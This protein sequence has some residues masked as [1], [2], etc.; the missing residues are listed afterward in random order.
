M[1]S[2][3]N[4][5][6]RLLGDAQ[7]LDAVAQLFGKLDIHCLQM[8]DAF[9]IGLG[10]R[11][12]DPKSN[13]RQDTAFV[14]GINT[15]NVE[16]RVGFGIAK[17]LGLLE[18]SLKTQA[19]FTHFGQD[20]IG[21]A[22]DDARQP[23][24]A[25][26]AQALA[27]RFDDG[28]ATSHSRFKTDH[29]TLALGSGKNLVAM[30]SQQGLVGGYHV[31]ASVNGAQHQL[32]GDAIA[33]NQFDDDVNLGV[34]DDLL[35]VRDHLAIAANQRMGFGSVQVG[36]HADDHGAAQAALDFSLVA[37]QDFIS[38]AANRSQSQQA[39]LNGFHASAFFR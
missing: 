13:R 30:H 11:H 9:N 31:F 3:F 37:L 14:G 28:N 7:Q 22:V 35:G 24:D 32:E 18:C 15:L 26:G 1:Y 38:A 16:C 34:G 39:N 17:C 4:A 36:H 25:V 5:I 23:F 12:G 29:H 21:G 10:K 19:L 2:E 6:G 20:E 8:D 33:A 27:Q